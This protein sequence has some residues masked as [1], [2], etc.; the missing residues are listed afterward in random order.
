LL[1][2]KN[3]YIATAIQVVVDQVISKTFARLVLKTA[4]GLL[5]RLEAK[6]GAEMF[7]RLGMKALTAVLKKLLTTMASRAA[8]KAGQVGVELAVQAQVA[9]STGPFA[10][11]VM[12]GEISLDILQIGL[13][14]L[15]IGDV[16]GY[17]AMGTLGTY[18]PIREIIDNT[19]TNAMVSASM[20][21]GPI[22]YGPMDKLNM[23]YTTCSG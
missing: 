23:S 12:M 19:V 5:G 4:I 17:N 14:A 13:M 20:T 3:L 10:P 6:L 21:P 7:A 9:A 11:F 2:D 18:L 8:V 1:T 16:A 22:V 15:D